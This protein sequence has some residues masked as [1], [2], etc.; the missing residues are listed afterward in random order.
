MRSESEYTKDIQKNPPSTKK[1]LRE[2]KN[3]IGKVRFREGV[4]ANRLIGSG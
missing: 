4:D 3:K 2:N 1:H